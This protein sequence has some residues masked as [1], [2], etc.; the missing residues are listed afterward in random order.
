MAKSLNRTSRR[1]EMPA[2]FDLR[3]RL[4]AFLRRRRVSGVSHLSDAMLR[5]IGLADRG[6]VELRKIERLRRP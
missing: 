5:D 2:P 3:A 1:S 6:L 4:R